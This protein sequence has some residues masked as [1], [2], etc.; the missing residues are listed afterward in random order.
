MADNRLAQNELMRRFC[1][2]EHILLI[3]PTEALQRQIE[4]GRNMYFPTDAHWNAAGHEFAADVVA[5]FLKQP[6]L[7]QN[8]E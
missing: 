2:E 4:S 6:G 8:N 3:D 1:H 7:D 5:D